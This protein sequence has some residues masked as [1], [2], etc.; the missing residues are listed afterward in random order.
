M[1]YSLI[2]I[3]HH[4][5]EL[6]GEIAI[7]SQQYK[8]TYLT[9]Q[10]LRLYTLNRIVKTNQSRRFHT[11]APGTWRASGARP[12]AAKTR[13]QRTIDAHPAGLGNFLAGTG[14]SIGPPLAQQIIQH[15]TVILEPATLI[16]QLTIPGKTKGFQRTQ[17]VVGRARHLTRRVEILHAQQPFPPLDSCLQEARHG[18]QQ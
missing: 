15:R 9:D 7:G 4:Y 5:G 1:V 14:A 10:I 11:Q 8:V 13:V 3:I 17:D 18:C 6:I 16:T 12:V 2:S